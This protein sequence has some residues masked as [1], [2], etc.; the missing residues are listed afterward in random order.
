MTMVS[1]AYQIMQGCD[2]L[3]VVHALVVGFTGSLKGW[4]DD[5]LTS[6]EK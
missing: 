2:D 3:A 5:H 1:T 6:L 4:W